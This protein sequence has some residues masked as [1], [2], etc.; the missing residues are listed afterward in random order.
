[1]YKSVTK[2]RMKQKKSLHRNLKDTAVKTRRS[3]EEMA[4]KKVGTKKLDQYYWWT[5]GEGGKTL[6]KS[7]FFVHLSS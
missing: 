4:I 7:F 6:K 5:S 2:R 3:I 1:M